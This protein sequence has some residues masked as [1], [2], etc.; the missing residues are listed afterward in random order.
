MYGLPHQTQ[1]DLEDSL[2]RTCAM[3]ADRVAL[4]GYAH[5]PHIVP[6]Q[7][8][9]D[10]GEMPDQ[11]LRFAMAAQGHDWLT[12]HGYAAV[13]FDHFAIAGRDPLALAAAN[14]LLRRNFQGL[15]RKSTRLNSSH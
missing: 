11:A 15:D 6:R 2:R 1:G 7:Q 5:V 4:F 8:A 12:A 10:A 9:V 14:G 13:G 3:G